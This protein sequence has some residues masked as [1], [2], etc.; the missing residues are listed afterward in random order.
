MRAETGGGIV[1]H[2][3]VKD[4]QSGSKLL[5]AA[6]QAIEKAFACCDE[7]L[8]RRRGEYHDRTIEDRTAGLLRQ[9]GI[10]IRIAAEQGRGLHELRP[11]ET[12][13]LGQL[14]TYKATLERDNQKI[15]F[16]LWA[17]Q[18]PDETA[19]LYIA[20]ET[21]RGLP[22]FE[23]FCA[24]QHLEPDSA[25]AKALWK[26]MQQFSRNVGSFFTAAERQ[27]LDRLTEPP[28]PER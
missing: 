3:I 17:E 14:T 18:M 27:Q 1:F 26:Q 8:D 16:P 24:D 4:E 23:K 20:K 6:T 25:A 9:S 12:E 28:A 21:A 11:A 19:A 10:R 13:V 7:D 22:K 5:A 2:A 15:E